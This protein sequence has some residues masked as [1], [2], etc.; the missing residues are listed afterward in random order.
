MSL[1]EVGFG[2]VDEAILGEDVDGFVDLFDG[3]GEGEFEQDEAHCAV[4][5]GE[6]EAAGVVGEFEHGWLVAAGWF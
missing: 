4:G 2:V 1:D 3:I 6:V 5:F